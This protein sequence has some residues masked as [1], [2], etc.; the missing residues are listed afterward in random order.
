MQ[1]DR[2]TDRHADCN[3]SY[4]PIRGEAINEMQQC[5]DMLDANAMFM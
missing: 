1:A 3:T 4:P 2:Q 5:A